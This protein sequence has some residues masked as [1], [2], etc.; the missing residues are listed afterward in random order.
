[1]RICIEAGKCQPSGRIVPQVGP[2]T[3]SRGV[4]QK[5][6][7]FHKFPLYG[8]PI[9]A[10]KMNSIQQF[11]FKIEI[12]DGKGRPAPVDGPP[13]WLT[14]N[15]DVLALT[16]SADGMTCDVVAVGIP[17][18]AK[19]QVT[20]DADLGTGTESLIGTADVEVT[21]A[22]GKTIVMTPGPVVDQP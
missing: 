3:E 9:M 19:V 13:T 10:T 17:G 22:P 11:P 6:P 4:V 20:A 5:T 14:D 7:R 18:T 12:L 21:A 16:P 15:T 2:F 1:M 8:V